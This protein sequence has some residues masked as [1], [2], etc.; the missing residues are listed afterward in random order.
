MSTYEPPT[1]AKVAVTATWVG[2][3]AFTAG[4]WIAG[5]VYNRLVRR[6]S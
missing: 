4:W 6:R 5:T 2:S 3:L 1:L